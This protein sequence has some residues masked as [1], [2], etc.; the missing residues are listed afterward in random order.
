M[1][2]SRLTLLIVTVGFVLF[3]VSSF[4]AAATM[5]DWGMM[6]GGPGFSGY[7]AT[8]MPS[9]LK[10]AWKSTAAP[11]APVTLGGTV[12]TCTPN[13]PA[14]YGTIS[15]RG[16]S[17]GQM[18]WAGGGQD[19]AVFGLAS[20]QP[21]VE[22]GSKGVSFLYVAAEDE[23]GRAV[24]EGFDPVS[25]NRLWVTAVPWST[26]IAPIGGVDVNIPFPGFPAFFGFLWPYSA[27]CGYPSWCCPGAPPHVQR[28]GLGMVLNGATGASNNNYA[29]SPIENGRAVVFGST[30]YNIHE[31]E[32]WPP[33]SCPYAY[34]AGWCCSFPAQNYNPYYNRFQMVGNKTPAFTQLTPT[35]VA[36]DQTPSSYVE[37]C[38]KSQYFGPGTNAGDIG[39]ASTAHLLS[40]NGSQLSAR[41]PASTNGT[42]A[43]TAAFPVTADRDRVAAGNGVIVAINAATHT[44]LKISDSDGSLLGS[45]VYDASISVTSAVSLTNDVILFGDSDGAVHM[46]DLPSLR[47][48][49]RLVC[50]KSPVVGDLAVVGSEVLVAANDGTIV[51]LSW[52]GAG[53]EAR[54]SGYPQNGHQAIG[55]GGVNTLSGNMVFT[56]QDLSIPFAGL[57]INLFRTYNSQQA[58]S[59][60]LY[61][62]S[63]TVAAG[64]PAV[65]GTP[66]FSA[67]GPGWTHSYQ[68]AMRAQF[69]K[70]SGSTLFVEERGDGRQLGYTRSMNG[71]VFSPPGITESFTITGAGC[72]FSGTS[73]GIGFHLRKKRGLVREFDGQ[74]NL[75]RMEDTDGNVLAFTNT[76]AGAFKPGAGG[77]RLVAI[78]YAPAGSATLSCFPIPLSGA[79]VFLDYDAQARLSAVRA[80][81]PTGAKTYTTTYAYDASGRLT[82]VTATPFYQ[83]QYV[84]DTFDR[85]TSKTEPRAQPGEKRL[86]FTYDPVGR[87]S[88]IAKLDGTRLAAYSYDI[89]YTGGLQTVVDLFGTIQTS[90]TTYTYDA[91]GGVLSEVK[92]ALGGKTRYTWDA[93][94][95]QVSVIDPNGHSTTYFYDARNNVISQVDAL[96]AS[97]FFDYEPIFN[98]ITRK[99]DANGNEV[100]YAYDG[101]GNLTSTDQI[102]KAFNVSPF[103]EPATVFTE[104]HTYDGRGLRLST[105]NASGQQTFFGYDVIGNLTSVA[106]RLV[107]GP[108]TSTDFIT[109]YE[110]DKWGRRTAEIDA[111]GSRTEYTFDLEGRTTRIRYGVI[112][113]STV[114]LQ[115]VAY[116][117]DP[118]GRLIRQTGACCRVTNYTYDDQDRIVQVQDALTHTTTHTYDR[119]GELLTTKDANTNV[120]SFSY[121]PLHR[122]TQVTDAA[123]GAAAYTY[124]SVGN[125]LTA[126]DPNSHTTTYDYDPLNRLKLVTYGDLTQESRTFDA[127]GN[128]LTKTDAKGGGTTRTYTYDSLNR[129]RKVTLSDGTP[130]QFFAFDPVGNRTRAST[131]VDGAAYDITDAFDSLN[132]LT[133]ENIGV[134]SQTLA[135]KLMGYDKVGNRLS[136]V[137]DAPTTGPVDL[138]ISYAYDGMNRTTSVT[139]PGGVASYSYDEN[140]NLVRTQMPNQIAVEREYDLGNRLTRL[141][142]LRQPSGAAI[143]Y[144]EYTYDNT[145]NRTVIRDQMGLHQYTYDPIYRLTQAVEPG[146]G[147]QAFGYDPAGNR[148]T[149]TM[150][151]LATEAYSYNSV[152]ELQTV[153]AGAAQTTYTWDEAGN[154]ASR[155]SPGAKTDF[156]FDGLNR[157]TLVT[158]SSTTVSYGYDPSGQRVEQ[159]TNGAETWFVFDGFSVVM[160]LNA[161]KKP[162][163]VLVPGV[164]KTRLDLTSPLTE[165]YL[166]DGLGSVV[167]LT[168]SVGNPTQTY[169]YDPFGRTLNVKVDPFNRYRFVNPAHDDFTGLTYMNARWYDSL[170]GRFITRDPEGARRPTSV[171]NCNVTRD[172]GT[173]DAPSLRSQKYGAP[174]SRQ[175]APQAGSI[176]STQAYAF[177]TYVDNNP[178]N[179][180]DRSGRKEDEKKEK[181]KGPCEGE[182]RVATCDAKYNVDRCTA[183]CTNGEADGSD[184]DELR[185]CGHKCQRCHEWCLTNENV[186]K[187][188]CAGLDGHEYPGKGTKEEEKPEYQENLK[189]T[190]GPTGSVPAPKQAPEGASGGSGGSTGGGG[191]FGGGASF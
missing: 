86:S 153:Q 59:T 46:I 24:G 108:A 185:R 166:F 37:P 61:A 146:V 186:C 170:L 66:F 97:M 5:P 56:V 154:I 151:G 64:N 99:V 92:D 71:E 81:D 164:S 180:T 30:A 114:F 67:L 144:F 127:V 179:E 182:N 75:S 173:P 131:L 156:T 139:G 184:P 12:F 45:T 44:I 169:R 52:S 72:F 122:L 134:A 181:K 174:L 32:Y 49:Q 132:R 82:S 85:M 36:V 17:D 191:S 121:D 22:S 65:S 141:R 50:S 168:D 187:E 47:E 124:D 150:T 112:P 189:R 8:S 35:V 18:A 137:V 58:K 29:V 128:Q 95:N 4:G 115:E 126:T 119:N 55:P 80:P 161:A 145:T 165:Y 14:P 171:S 54:S 87:I 105:R 96:G 102:V 178:L 73:T 163:A 3:P 11:G 138:G 91:C 94:F 103:N 101:A 78:F 41:D 167:N 62:A 147:I 133:Q 190:G 1:R 130:S 9:S 143:S 48:R 26:V 98:R 111:N 2:T 155:A 53:C 57:A 21:A 120:T 177:Y 90:R 162:L 93:N 84:Y 42:L 135:S 188:G 20:R 51:K 110:V 136:L 6:R 140:G 16:M 149:R 183:G 117:Y 76:P 40:L 38:T 25:G 70:A 83:S 104:S 39:L 148:L 27:C 77:S 31:L 13:S 152:N 109:T 34:A 125:L 89:T 19:V 116:D 129:L 158:G 159:R 107:T 68:V 43:W 157:L 118:L 88:T 172:T 100:R 7:Q 142:N 106:R 123:N 28:Q 160:E 79:T 63:G 23:L 10:F 69:D 74:G 15:A 33:Y 176:E 113:A 60:S 175:A